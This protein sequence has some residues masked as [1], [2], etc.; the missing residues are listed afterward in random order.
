MSH[1][2]RRVLTATM[3]LFPLATCCAAI[4][5]AANNPVL[6][7]ETTS[8]SSETPSTPSKT[9]AEQALRRLLELIRTSHSIADFTPERLG[10]VMKTPINRWEDG[11][12]SGEKLTS[13]WSYGFQ[14]TQVQITKQERR[15][16][17]DF[18]FNTA[19]DEPPPMTGICQM[20]FD[21]FTA[22]LEAM[23]YTR[24]PYYDSAPPANM[25][26]PRLPHGRLMY[27]SFSGA[28]LYIEVYPRGEGH[29][30]I[31]KISHRCVKMLL[32]Y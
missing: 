9:T 3:A 4:P 26:Q 24:E 13:Q 1:T 22:E 31:E 2:I 8:M 20:D 12:G 14:M 11:Y 27:D 32:I 6:A 30:P 10:E 5:V 28:G 21:H 7:K 23:G 29:D 18:S 15:W 16:R 25:G 17:F 19:S